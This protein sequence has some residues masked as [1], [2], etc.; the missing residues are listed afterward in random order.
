M[1]AWIVCAG[2]GEA[3]PESAY[4]KAGNAYRHQKR[5]N[6]CFVDRYP[7]QWKPCSA[8][9]G[10][11]I[12][13]R[14]KRTPPTCRPCRAAQARGEP[15]GPTECRNCGAPFD[16]TRAHGLVHKYCRPERTDSR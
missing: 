9:C 14:A 6:A 5:C 12:G 3:W 10:K 8:G 13:S 2:C 7:Q 16:G 4:T 11:V 1:E 15:R